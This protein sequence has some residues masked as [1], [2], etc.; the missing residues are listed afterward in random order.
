MYGYSNSE[1]ADLYGYG[2][3]TPDDPEKEKEKAQSAA[4]LYGYDE[5]PEEQRAPPRRQQSR[6]RNSCV[7]RRDQEGGSLAVA[8]FLMGGPPKMSDKDLALEQFE[9]GTITT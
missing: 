3:A 8:E 4:S 2:D 5:E 9:L 1:A 6:R 7:I